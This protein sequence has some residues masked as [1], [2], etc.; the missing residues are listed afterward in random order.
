[1]SEIR[2][3]RS[4]LLPAL[5]SLAA[6][7]LLTPLML[8]HY[9]PSVDGGA[10]VLNASLLNRLIFENDSAVR[11]WYTLNPVV[12]PNLSGHLLL[13]G[14]LPFLPAHAAERM[15]IAIYVL[16]FLFAFRYLLRAVATE[17]QGLEFLSLP[18]VYNVHVFWGFYNFCL[19]LAVYLILVGFVLRHNHA[20][21]AVRGIVLAVLALLL[22]LSHGLVFLFAL[23]TVLFLAVWG[24][25]SN[26]PRTLR[27]LL[28][29]GLA[30]LPSLILAANFFSSGVPRA[31]RIAA[32]PSFRYSASLLFT[33]SPLAAFGLGER[34]LA[35]LF[36]LLIYGLVAFRLWRLRGNWCSPE[37]L[38]VAVVGMAGVFLFPVEAFGGTMITPRLVYFPVFLLI[39]WLATRPIPT[40]WRN[41]AIGVSLLVAGGMQLLRMPIYQRYDNELRQLNDSLEPYI[42]S[43]GVYAEVPGNITGPLTNAGRPS[44]P[45]IS[46]NAL[47]YQGISKRAMILSNYE[48]VLDH[49][50][51]LFRYGRDPRAMFEGNEPHVEMTESRLGQI[52]IDGLLAWCNL[53]GRGNCAENPFGEHYQ[54]DL[55]FR[56]PPEAR[57]FVRRR[58]PDIF[59]NDH[60]P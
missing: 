33:L 51:L 16:V 21:T 25:A 28:I 19:G 7:G 59:K 1:M 13:M 45:D 23:F 54:R 22:Y 48:A 31:E 15:L 55:T 12:V 49:F 47:V 37:L 43:N 44:L 34:L 41:V 4:I 10:H 24:R 40:A 36:A 26:I 20:W 17:T 38:L 46:P 58:G 57:W 9:F 6:A 27:S 29:P 2:L 53:S 8:F 56:R 39:A 32:W 42:R 5:F 18:L 50:P 30:F 3:N 14:L 60:G 11:D 52:P 35:A